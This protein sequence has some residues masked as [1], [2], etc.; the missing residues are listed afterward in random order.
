MIGAVM[1][2]EITTVMSIVDP[3]LIAAGLLAVLIV[4]SFR[5]GRGTE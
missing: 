4:V 2:T 1:Q 3:T 5:K